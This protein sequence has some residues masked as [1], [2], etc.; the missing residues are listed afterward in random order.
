MENID[1]SSSGLDSEWFMYPK[2][3]RYVVVKICDDG[4]G[5]PSDSQA[6]IFEPFYS[7][8]SPSRGLG[9]A[10]V[11]GVMGT[12]YGGL[13]VSSSTGEG[14]TVELA[15]PRSYPKLRIEIVFCR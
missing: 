12:L 5:I 7:T 4:N 6:K 9:L 2:A 13:R 14:T 3:D 15:F 1:F 8:K 10:V 11:S